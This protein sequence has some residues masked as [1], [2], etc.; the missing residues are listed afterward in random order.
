LF[1]GR[2]SYANG[3]NTL[4]IKDGAKA[5]L[6]GTNTSTIQ[7][8]VSSDN[9]TLMVSGT[10]S[11]LHCLGNNGELRIGT[12][13]GKNNKLIV[14]NGGYVYAKSS[15]IQIGVSSDN[16]TL[17]VSS[18]SHYGWEAGEVKRF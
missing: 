8:G 2:D 9:N 3:G 13:T 17:M 10:N 7:I 1:L 12:Y 15:T 6:N 14:E 16:N 18:N 5:Y 11:E 4:E